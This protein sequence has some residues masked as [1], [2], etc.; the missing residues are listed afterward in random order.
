[1]P[2]APYDPLEAVLQSARVRL[3]DAIQS[4][5]GDILTDLAAF[6]PQAVNNAWRRLQEYLADRGF[7]ALNREIILS[8]VPAWT[9]TDP[10]VFVWFN[11]ASYFDGT[12][13]QSAPVL[14]QD[15]I[16]PLD[17]FERVHG[18]NGIFLPM[19]QCF[20]GLPTANPAAGAQGVR[21][22]LNRLWEWRQE[23][24]Y[25]PG[26]NSNTDIRMRYAG[27]IADF[28]I[29][30][31]D[32]LSG[33]MTALQTT[34]PLVSGATIANGNTGSGFVVQVDAE[35]ML[36]TA[37]GGTNNPTVTR[38]TRGTVAATHAQGAAVTVL[39]WGIPVT[40]M[41]SLNSFAWYLCSEI[42]KARGDMD[43]GG[44]DQ[45][46]MEAAEQI[47]NRDYREGKRLY[48]RA[49]LGKMTDIRSRLGGAN[50]PAEGNQVV[51]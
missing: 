2:T 31:Q 32:T 21:A 7:A 30:A 8:N 28:L 40:I 43:A 41:R 24:I 50:S 12:N 34:L 38:G 29:G 15:M 10:G 6:T 47:W 26:A 19:D 33:S 37:N 39:A 14:P 16:S 51:Q 25:M 5:N 42:A 4:I 9:T 11:W 44:F 18:S 13:P 23:T 35:I 45:S 17:L 49:E 27:Y 36:I 22:N 1:M 20:N 3:N 46:A 48:K